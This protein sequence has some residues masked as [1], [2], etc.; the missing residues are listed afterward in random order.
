MSSQQKFA[1][2][3]AGATAVVLILLGVGLRW[4][5]WVTI[6]AAVGGCAVVFTAGVV[7][8]GNRTP[9]PEPVYLPPPPAPE[10][11]RPIQV[12]VVQGVNLASAWADYEFV[13]DVTVYWRTADN[14]LGTEHVRPG[15]TA[16]DLI[17]RRAA[18]VAAL[19]EPGMAVRL[20]HRLNDVL[21]VV[22]AD[23]LGRIQVWAD[24]VRIT[25]SDN[26]LDRLRSLS[27]IRKDK[28]LWEHKRRYESDKR[29]YLT[30]D[31]LR[32]TGSAVVW[33]L[34]RNESNVTGAVDLI[35]P[36]ARLSAAAKNEDVPDMFRHLLP[37][38]ALPP[39][40]PEQSRYPAAG[41][42]EASP[43][44]ASMNGSRSATGLVTGLMDAMDLDPDERALFAERVA[45]DMAA[46]GHEEAAAR[47]RAE[48]DVI[49]EQFT[50]APE[51]EPAGA[52]ESEEDAPSGEDAPG[53]DN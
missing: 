29:E 3:L 10:P 38:S 53:P 20:Q 45:M 22:E 14:A 33:W 23:R 25:L 48:F 50:E 31:V 12:E 2:A 11:P 52:A 27:D 40:E 36:M 51:P 6:V 37:T 15:A 4:P 46:M 47:I 42:D 30:N 43:G 18:E 13:F 26:D 24:N 16:V 5:V 1:A 49:S 21:G 41:S 7:G 17:I 28:A 19:V 8:R 9:L 44:F 32:S 39:P 34:S 35:G